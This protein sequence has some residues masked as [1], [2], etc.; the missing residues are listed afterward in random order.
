[1]YAQRNLIKMKHVI[2]AD[3]DNCRADRIIR[4]LF[5]DAGYAHVQKLFRQRDVKCN[6]KKISAADRLRT[7]DILE[8]FADL[9]EKKQQEPRRNE[10][11]FRRLQRMIVFENE[12]FFALN[13]PTGLAVQSGVKISMCV[14]TLIK[15]YS[16]CE[17]R[18]VHR[19]DRDTSGLLLIAKNQKSARKLTKLFR[20][21][22]IHKTYLAI[23]DGEIS[24][25]GLIENFL[26]KSFR[27]NEEKMHV[28]NE[29]QLAVTKYSSLELMGCYTLLELNPFTGRKHQL[30]AHCADVL[31]APIL[32]DK[33]YNPQPT[34]KELFLHASKLCIQELGV[35]ITAEIP[36]H[37]RKFLTDM[38]GVAQR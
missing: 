25:S 22:K 10:K 20:E 37:F 27:G 17:C 18:L 11:L 26:K 1:M 35:E 6:R 3:E 36:M 31:K 13:K 8:I 19:L 15:S 32:G 29:G 23:V 4:S 16:S 38:R 28:S 33:K 12:D 14:D 5:R 30:R 24:G 34:H 7:G 9:S 21:G 2:T